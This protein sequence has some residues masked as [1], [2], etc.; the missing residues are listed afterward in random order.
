MPDAPARSVTNGLKNADVLQP[1]DED[2][3]A[4]A[5]GA[6]ARRILTR[7][8]QIGP[9]T[10]WKDG[11]LSSAYGFLPPDESDAPVALR[12]SPGR[13]WSDLCERMPGIVARGRMRQSILERM[14]TIH[15]PRL[16]QLT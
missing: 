8:E 12:A 15:M 1:E 6:P 5:L 7:A 13:I 14:F 2:L 10:G 9:Q 3:L 4:F 16:Y 11:Y